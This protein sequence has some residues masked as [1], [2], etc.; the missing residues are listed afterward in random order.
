MRWLSR[1]LASR[2]RIAHLAALGRAVG[3]DSLAL[4]RRRTA[5]AIRR[6]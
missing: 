3:F 2:R 1:F 5:M 6:S 4:G